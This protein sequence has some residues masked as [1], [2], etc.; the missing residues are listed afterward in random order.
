MKRLLILFVVLALLMPAPAAAITMQNNSANQ[1][2]V[3]VRNQEKPSESSVTVQVTQIPAPEEHRTTEVNEAPQVKPK[4]S[5]YIRPMYVAPTT[6]PTVE[7][8]IAPTATATP[9]AVI[10]KEEKK[11]EAGLLSSFTSFSNSILSF[12]QSIF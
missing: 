9:T 4:Q 6:T 5:D 1:G 12:F 7:P 3:S 2:G 8:T 10:N 11:E